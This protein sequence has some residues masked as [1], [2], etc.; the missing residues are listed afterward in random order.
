MQ[1]LLTEVDLTLALLEASIP[2][3]PVSPR[4]QRLE[5]SLESELRKY[6]RSLEDAFPF[7]KVAA[8]YN[9]LVTE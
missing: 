1:E 4:N 5:S 2:A 9:R 7:E 6:F 3:S 8:L